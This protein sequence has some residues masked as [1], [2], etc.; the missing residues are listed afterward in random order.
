MDATHPALSA[1]LKQAGYLPARN[2]GLAERTEAAGP[3]TI[4]HPS[5]DQLL[6]RGRI[7]ELGNTNRLKDEFLATVCHELRTPI[8]AIQNAA[9]V[10]RRT[11]NADA[12]L[13]NQMHELI[14]RQ[15]RQM[16]LLVAG[17]LDITRIARGELALH[18][19]AL[20]LRTILRDAAQTLEWGFKRRGQRLT[21]SVPES[22]VLL[23]ADSSRLEQ[24][25]VNLLGNASK[26]SYEGGE[27]A[28]SLHISDRYASV[29]IRDFGMGI[30]PD[31]LPLIFRLFMQ[32]GA[33]APCSG[34]GLGIGLALVRAIVEEHGGNVSAVSAGLCQGS[35][36]TVRLPIE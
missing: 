16:A 6:S 23:F 21:V 10:L 8:G 3:S 24:V 5:A 26:Y 12:I 34:S 25:F 35:E 2:T 29:R 22:S 32:V 9:R 36:F 14:E 15:A 4:E 30:A 19:E 31:A 13:K 28:L 33:A 11:G 20:D 7:A 18:R 1:M 27:I 17:L